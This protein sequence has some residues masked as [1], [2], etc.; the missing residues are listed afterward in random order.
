[1][2]RSQGPQIAVIGLGAAGCAALY[3]LAR[4]GVRAIGIERFDL[5]HAYGSSHG[6]TRIIRLA[7]FENTAYVP[8]MRRAYTL[9]R[10]L[11]SAAGTKLIFTTGIAEIGPA[12]GELVRGTVAG[13]AQYGLAHEVM[14][15]QSL[16]RR[17]ANFKLP[18]SFVAVVSPDGGYVT[19]ANA[20]AANIR[21]AAA[22]GAVIRSQETVVAIEPLPNGV[23]IKTNR[24]TIEADGAIAAAGPWLHKLL[25][26]LH[27]PLRATRQVTGWFE[28]DDASQF[29]DD[30]F[31]VFILETEH[32]QHYG[33]PAYG[34]RG[35][36]IAKHH[37]LGEVVDA[38]S[39]DRTVSVADEAAIRA[40][41][42]EYLP[43]ANG[44]LLNAETCLYTM[45]PDGT[46][47]IDRMPE[48]PH[49][50]IASPCCG[51]G[52]KF[53]PAVG[54]ILADLVTRSETPHDIAQFRLSRFR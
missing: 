42:A 34:E 30:R 31:P 45:T 4:R 52:F 23:R 17:Y 40:P 38:E 19:A 16:M 1:M 46:F 48:F 28:P 51:H 49:V 44:R 50:V 39:C 22:A 14:D 32:G 2:S 37:H 13:A 20:L 27:L 33:F 8:L 35:I 36:K 9:W 10:E 3:Q 53:S 24:D 5:G 12:D 6:P 26:E 11:E 25:P 47:I 43:A 18:R 54:E 41:L 29:S 7:H 15:A 21:L